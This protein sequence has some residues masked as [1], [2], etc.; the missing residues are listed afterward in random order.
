MSES[1]Y[2]SLLTLD[3]VANRLARAWPS[4]VHAMHRMV[5]SGFPASEDPAARRALG[6]LFRTDTMDRRTHVLVQ[7]A[8]EPDWSPLDADF[9]A[10]P[11]RTRDAGALLCLPTGAHL[12]FR[13]VA[14]P[15]RAI[16]PPGR[17]SRHAQHVPLRRDE[18]QNG[19][20]GWL[21]RKAEQGGFSVHL[22]T[23][24]AAD[25]PLMRGRRD[26]NAWLTIE[27]CRF[28]GILEITDAERFRVSIM[29]G[30]GR[31]KA[32]GCGLLSV[33]RP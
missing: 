21:L 22:E 30:I 3:P 16:R 32:Y 18:G 24:V 33:G 15:T 12:R 8:V 20:L 5:M 10:E 19:R 4:D 25:Q 17:D 28:E 27:P 26:G 6:V 7:S 29:S 11:V 14:N 9:F 31:A 2:L 23:V 1:L 13:L